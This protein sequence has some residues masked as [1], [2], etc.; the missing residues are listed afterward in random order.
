MT[1]AGLWIASPP[2][3]SSDD[4]VLSMGECLAQSLN[5]SVEG[6]PHPTEWDGVFRP[7]LEL[8]RVK[9]WNVFAKGAFLVG[10]EAESDEI[11]LTPHRNL[12]AKDGFESIPE[13][14]M[15]LSAKASAQ[16]LGDALS[17]VIKYSL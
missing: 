15:T 1:T 3:L 10:I 11:T 7:I 13:K 9:S 5:A 8:A 2:F 4:E 14:N 6:V 17:E 16:E 12:G